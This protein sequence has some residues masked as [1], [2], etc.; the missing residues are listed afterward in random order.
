MKRIEKVLFGLENCECLEFS[1]E[2]I[3]YLFMTNICNN[4]HW[5]NNYL[6]EHYTC[7]YF[8]IKLLSPSNNKEADLTKFSTSPL[9]FERLQQYP[10]LVSVLL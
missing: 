6:M 9:P 1:G 5:S 8:A 2:Q 7:D 4:I 3:S 10:D